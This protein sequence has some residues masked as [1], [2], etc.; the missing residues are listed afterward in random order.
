ME[1]DPTPATTTSP[2]SKP[3]TSE[4]NPE[5]DTYIRLLFILLLIDSKATDKAMLLASKTAERIHELNRRTL[6]P[7]A[8]KIF[9]YLS[10]A[11]E[12]S[13]KLAEIRP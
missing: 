4:P 1:V 12:L 8:A 2:A 9:F 11:Y 13:G 6:D 7:V 3:V 5:V 10:R